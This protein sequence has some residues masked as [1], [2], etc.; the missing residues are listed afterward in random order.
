M[1]S[2]ISA[3]LPVACLALLVGT[4]D[5]FAQ[6]D[7][8]V[9]DAG[10]SIA[11]Q[12]S[13]GATVEGA[14]SVAFQNSGYG[15]VGNGV[16]V[17]FQGAI[18]VTTNLSAAAFT[19]SGPATYS[20]SGTLF[21]QATAPPGQ[22]TI[23]FAPVAG[24]KTPKQQ[25]QTLSNGG[26]ISFN[27]T[28]SPM[29]TLG[30]SP[31]TLTFAYQQGI[32]GPPSPQTVTVSSSGP[33]LNFTAAASTT[34]PGG[35]WLA[36]SP[37]K[38]N[39]GTSSATLAVSFNPEGLAV[40]TYN[41]QITITSPGASTSPLTVPV[42][43][44]VVA[45]CTPPQNL[46]G[47]ATGT[48]GFGDVVISNIQVGQCSTQASMQIQSSVAAWLGVTMNSPQTMAFA[49]DLNAGLAGVAATFSLVPP[50][51]T[52]LVQCTSPGVA[53]WIVVTT[54]SGMAEIDLGMTPVAAVV[55]LADLILSE[56]S[57]VVA[58]IPTVVNVG[59]QLYAAVPDFKAAADCYASPPSL[60]NAVCITDSMI[61]LSLNE[62]E[63]GEAA[64]ILASAGVNVTVKA[65]VSAILDTPDKALLQIGTLSAMYY[66]TGLLGHFAVEVI[67]V[68]AQ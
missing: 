29:P 28:Y 11:F 55:N 65:L 3:P 33:A 46:Y 10:V 14:V 62:H 27:G 45:Q 63:L 51:S 15:T 20:G 66:Q 68:Q 18:F 7:T 39:T 50:C 30:V 48:G 1:K 59:N 44:T 61:A 16:T 36:V 31:L 37:T 25:T 34:P 32:A 19:V 58:S 56:A 54:S 52:N 24:Y 57:T 41:G 67:D 53:N 38:G 21:N 4:V 26:N 35:S 8:A 47:D 49:P 12:N 22:Y 60:S 42:T 23:S 9:A 6:S 5:L 17:F 2:I 40:G 64:R 43:L 13:G